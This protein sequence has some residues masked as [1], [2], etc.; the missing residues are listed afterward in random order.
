MT[1]LLVVFLWGHDGRPT[2]E[3]YAYDEKRVCEGGVSLART[4]FEDRFIAA[5]CTLAEPI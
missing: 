4:Y 3:A 1:W 5:A 2:I